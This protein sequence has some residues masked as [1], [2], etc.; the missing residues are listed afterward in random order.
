MKIL[1][2]GATGMIGQAVLK[3]ALRSPRVEAVTIVGRTGSGVREAKVREV[4]VKDLFDLAPIAE[5]LAG[6]DACIF[7]IGVSSAFMDEA[8]YARL[9]YDLTLSVARAVLGAN[10][11]LTFVYVTGQGTDSTEKGS[12][13]WARVKGRTENA[14]LAMPFKA[15]YMFRPGV[16]LPLDGIRPKSPV[17]LAVYRVL[18]PLV[19]LLRAVRPAW[20]PS[21]REIGRAMLAVANGEHPKH[22]L[23]NSDIVELARAATL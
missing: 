19:A 6:H 21:T 17:Y 9:T 10:P 13:M 5:D 12:T 20:I 23:D 22:I 18:T 14:L 2:F 7:C 1:L 11:K 16:I 15:A 3:E 8:A 4:L